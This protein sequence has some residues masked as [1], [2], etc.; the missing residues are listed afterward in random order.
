MNFMK[1][2]PMLSKDRN[3][4]KNQPSS[5]NLSSLYLSPSLG[6]ILLLAIFLISAAKTS[7]SA[8]D[9]AVVSEYSW[10]STGL[11]CF[12]TGTGTNDQIH[13]VRYE[14]QN[15]KFE[16]LFTKT[17]GHPVK[18]P[19]CLTNGAIVV[20]VDGVIRRLD[21]KGDYVFVAK[22]KGFEGLAEQIGRLDDHHIFMVGRDFNEKT[23]AVQYRL[24]VV[25]ISGTEPVLKKKFD[26]IAPYRITL[27]LDEI[28]VVGETNVLRLKD[29]ERFK[30]E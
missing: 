7:C 26:I 30:E 17:I 25:N 14:I 3:R 18:P 11:F 13:M 28:I 4:L 19:I 1:N 16:R 2:E 22:P 20:S 24:Y 21:L 15:E 5:T 29:P 8:A 27:T 23:N 10:L 12:R 6:M 9:F